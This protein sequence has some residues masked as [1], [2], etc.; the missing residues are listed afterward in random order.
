MEEDARLNMRLTVEKRDG[1]LYPV[2]PAEYEALSVFLLGDVQGGDG[3][4]WLNLI[5]AV[6][7]GERPS[8][9]ATGNATTV[10]I[11]PET[12]HLV[13]EF[14]DP[15]LECTVPAPLLRQIIVE[16]VAANGSWRKHGK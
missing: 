8:A 6:L 10:T 3:K 2:L 13:N 12:S 15:K 9:E 1:L 16:W 11:G 14:A 4:D 5:D 7:T